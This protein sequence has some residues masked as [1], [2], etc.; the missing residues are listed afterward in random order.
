MLFPVS[1]LTWDKFIYPRG[2]KSDKT[3]SA[4]VEALEIGAQFP[5]IRIQ[6]VLNYTDADGNEI[7]EVTIILDG[8]HRWFAFKE[9]GIKEIAAVE[10][11]D[12]PIDYEKNK[13]ALLLESAKY[14]T[15][16]GDRLSSND[17]KRVA[18]DIAS[19]DPECKWTESALAEKLGVIQQTVNTWI[20]D[21]RARQ[22][23][24]RN[25]TIIRL[26][27]LGWS[28]EKIAEVVGLDR[29]VISKNVQNTKI[30]DMHTLLAQ[31]H[32]MEYI[33]RHY[34]MDLPL[35][36]ALRLEGKTDQ[37][38]FKELGWGLRT[39]DQWSFNECDERFGDDWPGRIP[40]QLIAHTLFFFTK[41]GD[42]VLDPMAGGGVVSDVCL[43]FE[44]KCQAF[45][46][47]TRDNRPEIQYHYWDPQKWTWPVTKKPD[48]IF[49]D[50]PYYIKKEKAY[51]EK[52]NEKAP[53]ISSCT[54]EEYERFFEGFFTLA[55]KQ[56]K[57]TTRMAFLNAD[58]RDF[59]STPA[60][61]EKPDKSITIFDY[62]RLLSKTG[63]ETIH[64]IE[65]PL[66][67]ERLSGNQVQR[68]QD[69][70][71]LGTVGRTLLI[72]KRS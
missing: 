51:R 35:A 42:L 27:R 13:T 18:R 6:R 59:E 39:W 25:T 4:Y 24:S 40:A 9:K 49:F 28:Q 14:N 15:S 67:S 2:S 16:H 33:A 44:R 10:W 61:K 66:S 64:R 36:W 57:E 30:S 48:L 31:G 47:T 22:K 23:A 72:A 50:P 37:E 68:M 46:L 53:S 38:K 8:I 41:P 11:K 34:N 20:S 45:D 65:C 17:K 63:W 69:K 52:A 54:R 60:S 1:D 29:S 55:H 56:S 62:H 70:R 7:I 43:L 21:I 19:T 71:I 26:S 58:W 32:D 5:P 3:I 12:R